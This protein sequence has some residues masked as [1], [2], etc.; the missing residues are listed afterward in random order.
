[1]L[2]HI[3]Y[4][5]VPRQIQLE[6]FDQ[7]EECI[8]S[9]YTKIILCAPTGVGKSLIGVTIARKFGSSFIVTASKNL[10]NQ[11]VNDFNFLK[12]V[13]GKSNFPCHQTMTDKRVDD[14][15]FA[16][17]QGMTCEKGKCVTK[18]ITNGKTETN[19][20]RFKPTI[21]EVEEDDNI[22]PETCKY[23]LQKYRG[24]V[25]DHSL[26]NY[27]SFFQVVKF[28][29]KIFAKHLDRNVAVFDEAHT[30]EEQIVQFIGY[31]IKQ[32]QVEDANI[33]IDRYDLDNT[34]EILSIITEIS[35][36]YS[37]RIRDI[38]ETA[39]PQTHPEY[40]ILSR[41]Q[42][43]YEAA[44][45]AKIDITADKENFI[46]N[47]PEMDINNKLKTLSIKPIDI[48]GYLEEFLIAEN[49]V[50]MSATIDKASFCENM[51][52]DRDDV[53]IIDTPKSPFSV[54]SR[55]VE[56][57]RI[58][59]L[60]YQSTYEDEK[61]VIKAIDDI[62]DT[63]SDKRGLILT[64]S[65]AR[66][67]K[68]LNELSPHN[69]QRVRICHST[70][71]NGKTQGEIINEHKND[72]DGVLLSSSLWEGIDLKD[73]LSRFQIIA[74]VPYPNYAENRTRIKMRRFP[75]WYQSRTL[76]KMLQGM[77]RSVRNDEDWA[78][79]Y[80]LDGA[81]DKLLRMRNMIPKSYHDVLGMDTQ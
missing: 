67:Y 57:S 62:M 81:V 7:I 34:D 79:T 36:H 70:N 19:T 26:W 69:K 64:S 35:K 1:M 8:G 56:I 2:D 20:C 28:N 10:Q 14:P 80:I 23:Y 45:Q 47:K 63:Y 66:C 49:N 71:P 74:K 13:K 11:Y 24:L 41:L 76:T 16:V 9:G 21:Q 51:G 50:F 25:H 52:L 78:K 39:D 30:I 18:K 4:P 54:E 37:E 22:T 17:R 40:G 38:E 53:A 46:A 27:A 61:A 72:P 60:N 29:K 43:N 31:D 65:I 48:S 5:F 3:P 55:A 58:R 59:H 44:A 75:S 68:I 77:G 12:S 32:R 42:S 15:I 6:I 33:A 73:D